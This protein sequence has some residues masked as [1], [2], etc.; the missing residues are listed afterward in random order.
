MKLRDVVIACVKGVLYVEGRLCIFQAPIVE[1]M[2]IFQL[3]FVSSNQSSA[4]AHSEKEGFQK[5]S[6]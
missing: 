2:L 4:S 5:S 1:N 3:N 6:S